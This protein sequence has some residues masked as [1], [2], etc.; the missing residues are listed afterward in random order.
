MIYI[1]LSIACSTCILIIFRFCSPQ[2][3]DTR[4]TI[5]ISYFVSAITGAVVFSVTPEAIFSKWL[6][7]GAILGA[8]F[9]AV[10]LLMGRS[11]KCN[12]IAVTSVASKMSVVIPITLGIVALDEHVNT[13][14]IG[15]V[16]V[17]L[18]AVW[19]TIG[20]NV[21]LNG[22]LWPLLV[23]LG[24]GLIDFSFKL[25][26]V[27]GLTTAEFPVFYRYRIFLCVFNWTDP[28]FFIA[29]QNHY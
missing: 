13:I 3:A 12:G 23:F 29:P 27:K 25:I 8:T 17:G 18:V 28:L 26:Q 2:G 5:L 21:S 9:Y 22:W 7:P 20:G 15:G 14:I 16:L 19:L 24:S 1:L 10:F 6:F 4:H 11:T